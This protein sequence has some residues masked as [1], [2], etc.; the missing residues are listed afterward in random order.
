MDELTSIMKEILSELKQMNSKLDII[1]G[2][3]ETGDRFCSLNDIY[4]AVDYLHDNMIKL[5]GKTVD[6]INENGCTYIRPY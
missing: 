2:T 6:A 4:G 5:A 1:V 3:G